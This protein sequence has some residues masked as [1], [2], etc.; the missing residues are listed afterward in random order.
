MTYCQFKINILEAEI[1][2]SSLQLPPHHL[3]SCSRSQRKRGSSESAG[4][5]TSYIGEIPIFLPS[6]RRTENLAY[7]IYYSTYKPTSIEALRKRS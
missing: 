3:L 4:K 5:R 1:A 6:L 7:V 2:A